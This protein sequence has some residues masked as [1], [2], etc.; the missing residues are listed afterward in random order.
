VPAYRVTYSYRSQPA[1]G[2]GRIWEPVLQFQRV[3]S[4]R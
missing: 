1:H 2:I 4:A 3:L